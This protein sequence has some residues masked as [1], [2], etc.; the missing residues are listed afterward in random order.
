LQDLSL[1]KQRVLQ[2]NEQVLAND[3]FVV[4]AREHAKHKGQIALSH[5]GLYTGLPGFRV[6]LIRPAFYGA[7]LIRAVRL[8][9]CRKNS[10][11]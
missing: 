8:K 3:E 11:A 9:N 4:F 2:R 5:A 1:G 7:G 10:Y 6:R